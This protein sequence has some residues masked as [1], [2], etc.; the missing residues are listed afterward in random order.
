MRDERLDYSY[1]TSSRTEYHHSK[2]Q[3][4]NNI[5]LLYF[6]FGRYT[7]GARDSVAKTAYDVYIVRHL[8]SD[9]LSGERGQNAAY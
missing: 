8:G 4:K 9:V 5:R 7:Q 6:H 3:L 2:E 1:R